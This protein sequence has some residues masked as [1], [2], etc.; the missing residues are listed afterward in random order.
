VW[1]A[2]RDQADVKLT[3]WPGPQ[4]SSGVGAVTP[5][6]PSVATGTASTR[7]FGTNLHVAVVTAVAD[8]TAILPGSI[9]SYDL[10]IGSE[11]LLSLKLLEDEAPDARLPGV[12]ES[13]P[14]HLAL[15]YQ[16][17]RLPSFAT[18]A[19]VLSDLCL[20]HAS[21]RRTN[22]AGPDAMAYLDDI[23]EERRMDIACRPQ[24]LFLTG[25][26]I[27]A[28]DLAGC[29][30]PQINAVGRELVGFTEELPIDNANI[31]VN[32]DEF[33]ALRRR[34]LVR[35]IARFTTT[36]GI[37]HLLSYG[38][39]TAMHLLVWSPRMWRPL[40][41][42]DDVF[43]PS[44]KVD[45]NHL[46]DWEAQHGSTGD[47]KTKQSG[48]FERE[49]ERVEVFRDAVPR[50]A[51]ALANTATYMIFDD[52][53][54]TDDWYLSESWRSRVLTA[55]FGRAV[56]RNGL[57]AYTVCQAWGNDPEAFSHEGAGTKPKNEQLLDTLETIG[58][59]QTISDTSRAQLEK[60]F[61]MEKPVQ[62]PQVT[63]HYSVPSARHMVRVLDTRTRR[64]YKGRQGPPRLLGK[65]M[66]AQ[67][68]KGP[69]TDGRELLVVVSAPPVF[70]VRLFDTLIQPLSS[71]IFDFFANVKEAA[72]ADFDGPPITG[73]DKYDV[74]GWGVDEVILEEMIE[75]LSTYPKAIVLSGDV[76]FASSLALDYWKGAAETVAARVV[77]LTSSAA[78][79]GAGSD[80]Q[81]LI[82]AA[83]FSQQLLRGLP[84]ERLGWKAKTSIAVP[85]G[86]AVSPARRSR[87]RRS[88]SVL[89]AS[90]W[91]IGTTIPVDKPPDFR[92]RLTVLRDTTPRD[93]MLHPDR[94]QPPLPA[95]DP[96][97]PLDSYHAIA[98]VHSQLAFAPTELL[99]TFVFRTNVGIV[100]VETSGSELGVVHEL[101]SMDGPDSAEGGPFTRHRSSLSE[102]PA[103][104]APQLQVVSDG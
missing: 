63:F 72:K 77:Q 61:G 42:V 26:Q 18:S 91:P 30:L 35:E 67:L 31:A 90:G 43:V 4:I 36:D 45:E 27:Y 29:L 74:E 8:G 79:N 12:D 86:E 13:A 98:G 55:P 28:D 20:A 7:R 99:R 76:H 88:P 32:M 33:P 51:R 59:G 73:N 92:W 75:R 21:C 16:K 60:L 87:M 25:D 56:T 15:G 103:S 1:I 82:R 71:R 68:P 94:L 100:R 17:N 104:V 38:E 65:S 85:T 50:V 66:N 48:S 64:T 57:M 44:D 95:Y 83:R 24:Q 96:A 37:N 23:I 5:D 97:A 47:W 81:A 3:V 40:A 34:H 54:V 41:T 89:P 22:A 46:Q 93:K 19:P 101:W 39:F 70:W 69:L 52:H 49:V 6:V 9:Y 11:N 102:T 58:T 14:L 53:E 78:R 62:D 80:E 2:L 84:M 10:Q